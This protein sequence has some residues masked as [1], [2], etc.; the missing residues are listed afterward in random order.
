M[1]EITTFFRSP[2]N[3][4]TQFSKTLQQISVENIK[5]NYAPKLIANKEKYV[6][7]PIVIHSWINNDDTI[8]KH[9]ET[10]I[11]DKEQDHDVYNIQKRGE[12]DPIVNVAR[13]S[14]GSASQGEKYIP[15]RCTVCGKI[16]KELHVLMRKIHYPCDQNKCCF[17]RPNGLMISI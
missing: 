1:A 5:N 14:P 13:L 9:E 10:S 15:K 4:L 16:Q 17:C 2:D 6:I 7:L 12:Y 3:H 11:C 8:K